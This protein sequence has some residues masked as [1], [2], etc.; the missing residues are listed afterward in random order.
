MPQLELFPLLHIAFLS[1]ASSSMFVLDPLTP[2]LVSSSAH[3][4]CWL[5]SWTSVSPCPLR[6][7]PLAAVVLKYTPFWNQSKN[8][9]KK[10]TNSVQFSPSCCQIS[11]SLCFP[12]PSNV[13]KEQHFVHCV[14]FLM[15]NL[16]LRQEHLASCPHHSVLKCSLK[17]HH[18]FTANF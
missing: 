6:N 10:P 3:Y 15:S 12:S 2:S 1:R 8:K 14:Y 4:R 13:L 9:N 16:L 7:S 5:C 11:L 18:D 17:S